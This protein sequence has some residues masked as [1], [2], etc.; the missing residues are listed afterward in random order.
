MLIFFGAD[1]F[2]N[3][4]ERSFLQN[5]VAGLAFLISLSSV[6]FIV[7][8]L[9]LKGIGIVGLISVLVIWTVLLCLVTFIKEP[10]TTEQASS[11]GWALLFSGINVAFALILFF[12]YKRGL[13]N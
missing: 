11:A 10:E 5:L 1:F 12:T 6:Y 7:M 4:S 13:S 2:V 9:K 3:L 8:S